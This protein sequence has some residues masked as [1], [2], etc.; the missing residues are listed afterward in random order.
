MLTSVAPRQETADAARKFNRAPMNFFDALPSLRTN[1]NQE[2]NMLRSRLIHT[3]A[4]AG[5][6]VGLGGT[7]NAQPDTLPDPA[8]VVKWASLTKYL[9]DEFR[10]DQRSAIANIEG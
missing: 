10:I 4:L 6:V 1:H 9:I 2:S 8:L 5:L 3:L 7:A